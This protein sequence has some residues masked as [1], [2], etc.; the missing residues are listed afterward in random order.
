MTRGRLRYVINGESVL[1]EA[2][3]CIFVNSRNLHFGVRE[4]DEEGEFICLIIHPSVISHK[5]A[6]HLLEKISGSGTQPYLVLNSDSPAEKRVIDF[7]KSIHI[8]ADEQNDGFEFDVMS[9]IYS[10]FGAVKQQMERI[11]TA[12]LPDSKQLEAIRRMVGYIQKNYPSKIS[13]NDIA[14]AGLVCRRSCC[15]L[16]RSF[17]EK[18]PNDYLTEYRIY[19]SAE[20]LTESSLSITEI[21]VGCGFCSSSYFT[22]VFG[23]VME[24]T[25]KEYRNRMC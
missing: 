6:G 1:L 22:E 14:A 2:G 5:L 20:M 8:A 15:N 24:C 17:L 10:L 4:N 11:H 13:V 23:R 9:G 7:V 3:S 25:P 21:A 16:F 18:T 19:K 12:M